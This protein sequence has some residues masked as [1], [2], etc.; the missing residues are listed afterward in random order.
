MF[1]YNRFWH[2][3]S[4][5]D[6]RH[7]FRMVA[8]AAAIAVAASLIFFPVAWAAALGLTALGVALVAVVA[9][10]L[11][12]GLIITSLNKLSDFI[13]S[14][15]NQQLEN[16]KRVIDP[17]TPMINDSKNAQFNEQLDLY[18]N[19]RVVYPKELLA[20]RTLDLSK[21]VEKR[22]VSA[23]S[24][25]K[26]LMLNENTTLNIIKKGG[27][28]NRNTGYTAHSKNNENLYIKQAAAMDALSEVAARE[29]AEITGFKGLIPSNTVA[30]DVDLSVPP[31]PPINLGIFQLALPQS[32]QHAKPIESATLLHSRQ[33]IANAVAASSTVKNTTLV[34]DLVSKFIFNLKTAVYRTKI[35]EDTLSKL[36]YIQDFMPDVKDGSQWYLQLLEGTTVEKN[37]AKKLLNSID[38]TSFENNFL[39]QIVLGAQDANPGNTLFA[40]DK[41]NG[42]PVKTLYSID[43]ERIMP[44]NNYNITKS[45][46]TINGTNM[47]ERAIENVFPIRLWLAGLPQAEVPFSKETMIK[48]LNLLDPNRLLAYHRQKKLFSP[49]A[50]SAQIER[51]QLIRNLFEAELQ[52]PT[53]TLTPKALLLSLINNHPSYDLLKNT[54]GLCDLSTFMLVGQIP[55]DAD[56]SLFRHPLQWVPILGKASEALNNQQQEQS[57]L[58]SDESFKSR[59]APIF[60]FYNTSIQQLIVEKDLAPGFTVVT[61]ATERLKRGGI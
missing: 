40:D 32:Q 53:P 24:T 49:A 4:T 36:L 7:Y 55:E 19:R 56:V 8:I 35:Q 26:P 21:G 1:T 38:Q 33:T 52:K 50:V 31:P 41:K 16:L 11:V 47:I 58:F 30:K 12:V 3:W 60:M 37:E 10:G 48:T 22:S 57:K 34:Q 29:M 25:Q 45:I 6:N 59:Y 17:N 14:R 5:L 2:F 42:T 46:P 54:L 15:R 44:E 28:G 13:F 27:G 61:E 51:V 39:L 20:G 9:A 23:A 18:I 43:H